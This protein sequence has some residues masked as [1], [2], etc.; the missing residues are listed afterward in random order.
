MAFLKYKENLDLHTVFIY[1]FFLHTAIYTLCP[2]GQNAQLISTTILEL[3]TF[4]YI[5]CDMP[6]HN[7]DFKCMNKF[8]FPFFCYDILLQLMC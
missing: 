1:L 5:F 2:K 7:Y 3:E 8:A 4:T 6:G